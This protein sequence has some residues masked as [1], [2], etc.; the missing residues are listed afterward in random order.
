M[1]FPR[2]A[3]RG[4]AFLHWGVLGRW[5]RGLFAGEAGGGLELKEMLLSMSLVYFGGAVS[6]RVDFHCVMGASSL[7]SLL[8]KWWHGLSV[9]GSGNRL[10]V[11][12]M[13]LSTTSLVHV[14][15]M[16]SCMVDL[17]RVVLVSSLLSSLVKW[18]HGVSAGGVGN[19]LEWKKKK[20]SL[21]VSVVCLNGV[22]LG[23]VDLHWIVLA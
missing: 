20:M 3:G 15:G 11:E 19:G 1:T 5:W 9:G 10:K 21:S 2:G 4:G 22:V 17:Y 8:V 7:L 23:G 6:G 14:G 13:S 18:W 16:V 12:K